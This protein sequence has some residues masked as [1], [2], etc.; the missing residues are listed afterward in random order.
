M[1]TK[2]SYPRSHYPELQV[3]LLELPY[4]HAG[5]YGLFV[6]LPDQE[7]GL[8]RLER[9]LRHFT[10]ESMLSEKHWVRKAKVSGRRA[11]NDEAC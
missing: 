9:R 2:A 1:T 5:R 8:P 10:L 7:D 3:T 4:G 11:D 6:L